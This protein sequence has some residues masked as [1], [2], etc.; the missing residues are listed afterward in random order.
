MPE[1]IH[2]QRSFLKGLSEISKHT[3]FGNKKLRYLIHEKKFPAV[4]ILDTWVA[5]IDDIDIWFKAICRETIDKKF[6]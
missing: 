4:K 2:Y 5:V 6:N 3:G 1:K